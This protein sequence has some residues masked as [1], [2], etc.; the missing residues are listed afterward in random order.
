MTVHGSCLCGG[1]AWEVEGAFEF[2]HHCHCGRCRKLHGALFATDLMSRASDTGLVRGQELIARFES[3]PGSFRKFCRRCGSVV[4]DTEAAWQDFTF[5]P[6]GALDDDPGIRPVG[7]IFVGSKASWF[8]ITDDLPRFDDFPPGVDA[9]V[10]ADLA[11]SLA[12]TGAPR[13][14]CLCGGVTFMVA[15]APRAA[16]HCH[17]WRCRK[18]RGTAFASNLLTGADGFHLVQGEDLL[19][20]YKVP[21]ARFFATVFCARCGSK[22]PRISPE[23]GVTIVPLGSLDDDPGIRPQRHIYVGSKAPWDDITDD[24]PQDVAAPPAM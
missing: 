22:M 3:S 8:D 16:Y 7:H 23:R 5:M 18:A 17:C 14:S 20:S 10:L 24:L 4:T 12:P 9:S 6:A 2:M 21:E 1:V 15:G 13:G 11:P 19:V